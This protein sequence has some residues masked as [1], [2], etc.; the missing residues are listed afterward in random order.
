MA[1]NEAKEAKTVGLVDSEETLAAKIAEVREA[2]KIFSTYTQEQVDKIFQA[3]AYAANKQRISLAKM[4]VEETGMG[5]VED[6]VLSVLLFLQQTRHLPL[7]SRH[8][9]VLRQETV[10]SFPHTQELRSVQSKLQKSFTKQ[11]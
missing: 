11:L 9:F 4:A 5:I 1:K 8:L 6:K 3:A 7:Y 10:S 2:Q